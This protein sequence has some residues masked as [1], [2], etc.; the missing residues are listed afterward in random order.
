MTEYYVN[1]KC[2]APQ[3]RSP[4]SPAK[5]KTMEMRCDL[6]TVQGKT[7]RDQ[8]NYHSYYNSFTAWP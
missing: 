2:F 8:V 7:G 4:V 5:A 6:A 3:M 1:M